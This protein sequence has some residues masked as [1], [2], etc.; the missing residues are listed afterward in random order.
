MCNINHF[1]IVC[2]SK[3]LKKKKNSQMFIHRRLSKKAMACVYE[4]ILHNCLKRTKKL[5]N[6]EIK[7][8]KKKRSPVSLKVKKNK[9][10]TNTWSSLNSALCNRCSIMCIIGNRKKKTLKNKRK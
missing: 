2:N 4:G 3:R 5:S 8:K 1:C 7:K 9:T 6:M 10:K